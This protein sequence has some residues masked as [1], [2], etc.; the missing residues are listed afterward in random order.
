MAFSKKDLLFAAEYQFSE[1]R[2]IGRSYIFSLKT[3][4]RNWPDPESLARQYDEIDNSTDLVD[5]LERIR[6]SPELLENS[7]DPE[8]DILQIRSDI[9]CK[10][11]AGIFHLD[12]CKAPYVGCYV[13]PKR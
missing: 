3:T 6:N 2:L 7:W 9:I 13:F 11:I 5:L 12:Y 4:D 1:I 10:K 8:V